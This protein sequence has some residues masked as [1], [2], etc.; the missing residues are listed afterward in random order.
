[1]SSDEMPAKNRVIFFDNLRL[2]LVICV[3]LQHSA[4]AYSKLEWWPVA[5]H[6]TSVIVDGLRAFIDAI[7]MPLLFY[8][9]G[10]FAIPTIDKRA[11]LLS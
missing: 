8:I 10:Y 6:F 9:A 1:M 2:F 7:A 3:V 4:N 11:C 5:D